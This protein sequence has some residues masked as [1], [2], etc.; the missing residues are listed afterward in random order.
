MDK[1]N[2]ESNGCLH[3]PEYDYEEAILSLENEVGRALQSCNAVRKVLETGAQTLPE[4][5]AKVESLTDDIEILKAELKSKCEVTEM[6]KVAKKKLNKKWEQAIEHVRLQCSKEICDLKEKLKQKEAELK[7]TKLQLAEKE[8]EL[9]KK[10]TKLNEKSAHV[11]RLQNE[12]ENTKQK[13]ANQREEMNQELIESK[14]LAYSRE[15]HLEEI[16]ASSYYY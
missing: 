5:L 12:L 10:I 7:R 13:F 16:K 1:T 9:S 15:K 8:R 2:L 4:D 14:A 6:L 11:L 3:A